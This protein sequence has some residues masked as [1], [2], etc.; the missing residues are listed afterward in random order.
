LRKK[1]F[2]NEFGETPDQWAKRFGEQC[3]RE[4][5]SEFIAR[6]AQRYGNPAPLPRERALVL[7][8]G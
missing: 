3:A 6:W 7:R 5:G 2:T 8:D 4:L 1:L